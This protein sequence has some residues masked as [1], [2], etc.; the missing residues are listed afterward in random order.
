MGLVCGLLYS[1]CGQC[2]QCVVYKVQANCGLPR[3]GLSLRSTGEL[4]VA[5]QHAARGPTPVTNRVSEN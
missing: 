1:R 4:V 3:A 2:S 5:S